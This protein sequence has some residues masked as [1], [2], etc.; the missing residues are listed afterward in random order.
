VARTITPLAPTRKAAPAR[1]DRLTRRLLPVVAI[2][3]VALLLGL[4]VGAGH[5]PGEQKLAQKFA[6]AWSAGDYGAM[7][8]LLSDDARR[9]VSA[10]QFARAYRR[11]ATTATATGVSAGH[12]PDPDD[13]VVRL[14]VRVRTRVWGTVA[15]IVALPFSGDGDAARIDWEPNLVFPGLDKGELLRR[16]TALG[17]RGDILARNGDQ[18][19]TGPGRAVALP[20]VSGVVGEVGQAGPILRRKLRPLGYPPDARI[21]TSGLE[22][23]LNEQLAGTPGGI[24]RAGRHILA[25]STPR[26]GESVRTTIDPDAQKAAV[27]ALG[28]RLGGAAALKP[29]GQILAL[30]G[31]AA[32][33]LQPPGSTFKMI[34]LTAVLEAG[35]AKPSTAFPVQTATHLSGVRLENANGESCGGTLVESFAES[36]NSVFAPLGAKVG[37]RKLVATAEKFGFNQPVGIPGFAEST[38]PAAGKVG[39]D[40]AVGSTAIGQGDVQ[41]SALQMATIAATVANRGLRPTPRLELDSRAH[42]TR[43]TTP[44]VARTVAKMMVQVVREGTGTAAAIPGVVV[45]GK[46]GTAELGNTV[47]Q[48]G[49]KNQS[50]PDTDAW[51]AAFAPVRKP[52]IAVGVLL[53]QAGAGADVGAPAAHDL[54]AATLGKS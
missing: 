2:A 54:L 53:V 51:F 30:S 8:D 43:A 48:E 26:A 22:L 13:G 1:R 17:E 15:G 14:P 45:A 18:L 44:R 35:A 19:V 49:N 42:Y 6:V 31:I 16:H 50:A 3:G 40:L 4:I 37:A 12:A 25:R 28:D 20:A 46:T 7:Y 27:A 38:L 21:G 29:D 33:D 10:L 41:A 32:S 47:D 24:L 23:A 5:V 34:T 39:D 52:R 9:H 36:C 11:G